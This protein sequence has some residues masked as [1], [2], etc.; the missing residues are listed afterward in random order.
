M[1]ELGLLF[2]TYGKKHVPNH[3]PGLFVKTI[4]LS[5]SP[6]HPGQSWTAKKTWSKIAENSTKKK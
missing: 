3:Q 2:P 6:S 1:S 4:Q 5:T